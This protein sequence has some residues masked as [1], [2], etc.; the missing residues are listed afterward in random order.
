MTI[1]QPLVIGLILAFLFWTALARIV[2]GCSSRCARRST[3]R[4]RRPPGASD[5]RIIGRHMLPNYVGPIVVNMTLV[6]RGRDPHRGGPLVPR[7]RHP[8]SQAALGKLIADGQ[9]EGFNLWW[10]VTFPGLV[11]VA[12][13]LASTSSGTGCVMRSIR[14]SGAFVTEAARTTSLPS[15]TRKATR[16]REP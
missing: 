5:L 7:L 9:G 6:D 1:P 12:I 3:S 15:G 4:R 11:I 14:R 2:R 10:L 8:A 16:L 13:A